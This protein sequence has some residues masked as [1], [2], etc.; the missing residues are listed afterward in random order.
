MSNLRYLNQDGFERIP[1]ADVP[2]AT[3]ATIDKL[4]EHPFHKESSVGDTASTW[5][6]L[7]RLGP[8]LTCRVAAPR[9]DSPGFMVKLCFL[10]PSSCKNVPVERLA[11]VTGAL[12]PSLLPDMV[13]FGV[14]P[15]ISGLNPML[16]L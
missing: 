12:V 13:D 7:P 8:S 16:K 9:L 3:G 6:A 10:T 11:G 1:V 2:S 15:D 5:F 4:P 14:I